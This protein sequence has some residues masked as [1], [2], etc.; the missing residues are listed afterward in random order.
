M[1]VTSC[2][3]CGLIAHVEWRAVVESSDGPVE[4][5]KVRC[6]QGH[7]FLLPLSCLAA[8]TR[9]REAAGSASALAGGYPSR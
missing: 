1:D 8:A 7:W 5:A 4:L 3:G 2:P 6:V 9:E